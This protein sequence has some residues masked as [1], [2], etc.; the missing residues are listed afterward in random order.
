MHASE[1]IDFSH[2]CKPVTESTA[3]AVHRPPLGCEECLKIGSDWVHLR[4]CLSC[5][6]PSCCDDSPNRHATA[7]YRQT[8]HPLITLRGGRR[9]LGLLLRR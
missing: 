8:H 2:P 3:K 9:D 1:P 7:H 6:K 4:I 5:G